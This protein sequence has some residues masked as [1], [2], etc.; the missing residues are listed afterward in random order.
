MVL[1]KGQSGSTQSPHL[2]PKDYTPHE[3]PGWNEYIDDA[4]V[5]PAGSPYFLPQDSSVAAEQ[6]QIAEEFNLPFSS[7]DANLR[8]DPPPLTQEEK[9]INGIWPLIRTHAPQWSKDIYRNVMDFPWGGIKKGLHD[10]GKMFYDHGMFSDDIMD[11]LGWQP[12]EEY[13]GD[14]WW[15]DKMAGMDDSLQSLQEQLGELDPT[16][17][18]HL[19]LIELLNSDMDMKY[20][21]AQQ[22]LNLQDVIDLYDS[23]GLPLNTDRFMRRANK[24]GVQMTNRGGI[25]GLI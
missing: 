12:N 2:D 10:T 16:N 3:P 23:L 24:A 18:D 17:P 9:I 6:A 25:I 8:P 15:D 11:F 14:Y 4:F 21:W 5:A 22:A 19:D 13:Y 1:F 20:P 7:I